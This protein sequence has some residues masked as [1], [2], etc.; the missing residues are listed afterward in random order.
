MSKLLVKMS[1]AFFKE[2]DFLAINIYLQLKEK[3]PTVKLG[4]AAGAGRVFSLTIT[5][6]MKPASYHAVIAASALV[7]G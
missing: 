6:R 5:A 2:S 1:L 7:K 3:R 4:G